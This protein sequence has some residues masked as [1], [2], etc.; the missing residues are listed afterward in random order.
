MN[1]RTRLQGI[2][3]WLLR[4]WSSK[5]TYRKLCLKVCSTVYDVNPLT[6]N[7]LKT[8]PLNMGVA[9]FVHCSSLGINHQ[10]FLS[11]S[12]ILK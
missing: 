3:I 5:T 4:C 6:I 9:L 12:S 8:Q 2:E 1:G 11:M 7:S 10:S